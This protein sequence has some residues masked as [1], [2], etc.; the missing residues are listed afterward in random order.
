MNIKKLNDSEGK[1]KIFR[2]AAATNSQQ[3]PYSLFPK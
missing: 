3:M 1:D 2:S